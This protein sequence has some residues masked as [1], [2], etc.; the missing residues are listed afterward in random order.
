M[1][2]NAPQFY[3]CNMM[4]AHGFQPIPLPGQMMMHPAHG[5]NSVNGNIGA[6]PNQQPMPQPGTNNGRL[7]NVVP[8][9]KSPISSIRPSEIT[10]KQI[11]SLRSSLRYFEDQ[12]QY[13]KHQIDEKATEEQAQQIRNQIDHFGKI[14]GSQV[15]FEATNYPKS[16]SHTSSERL[17]VPKLGNMTAGHVV[18]VGPSSGQHGSEESTPNST[19]VTREKPR[20]RVI[21]PAKS[22][23]S[24]IRM[25]SQ[26]NLADSDV[27]HSKKSSSLPANAAAAKP[28]TP[29]AAPS[30]S[31]LTTVIND[32]CTP[33]PV[34][35]FFIPKGGSNWKG[36]FDR[37]QAHAGQNPYP[38]ACETAKDNESVYCRQTMN[39][40]LPTRRQ[41][42]AQSPFDDGEDLTQFRG[43]N[44]RPVSSKNISQT[45]SGD[46]LIGTS[47]TGNGRGIGHPSQNTDPFQGMALSG[48]DAI[49]SPHGD[50]TQSKSLQREEDTMLGVY[51]SDITRPFSCKTQVSEVFQ[52]F[53]HVGIA[54]DGDQD[55]SDC[56][57]L[58]GDSAKSSSKLASKETSDSKSPDRTPPDSGHTS[59]S[60]KEDGEKLIFRGRKSMQQGR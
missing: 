43:K 46:L 18:H 35:A 40:E 28:F 12:L 20:T 3:A 22:V 29:R 27:E 53:E 14:L 16:K 25:K 1:M 37:T 45:N 55:E 47:E 36:F 39:D 33:P 60:D 5:P 10:K 50:V 34:P 19:N 15:S 2:P 32:P 6:K 57:P 42:W 31:S 51:G 4:P 7:A 58:T 11:E 49:R 48:I 21:N 8:L 9:A 13:N 41:L 23:N 38:Q 44:F 26:I 17:D 56:S 59:S 54:D 30:N 52:S 24:F